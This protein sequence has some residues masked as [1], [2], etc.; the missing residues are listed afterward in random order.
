MVWEGARRCP[1]RKYF[2]LIES[3]EIIE[4]IFSFQQQVPAERQLDLLRVNALPGIVDGVI[5]RQGQ[6]LKRS[7]F[8][9]LKGL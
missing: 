3:D 2:L 1:N 7:E 6:D 4:S 5:C 9:Q 8:S